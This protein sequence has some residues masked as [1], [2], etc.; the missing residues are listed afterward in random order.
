MGD[1][2]RQQHWVENCGQTTVDKYTV[3]IDSL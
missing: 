2:C 3:T 1:G